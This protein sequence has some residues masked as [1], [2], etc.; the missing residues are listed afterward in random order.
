MKTTVIIPNYNGMQFLEDFI[1]SLREQKY[2]FETIVVDN[3]SGDDS[4]L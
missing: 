3:A 4:L 2:D 1:Y